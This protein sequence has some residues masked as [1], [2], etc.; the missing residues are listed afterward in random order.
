MNYD[1]SHCGNYSNHISQTFLSH[2]SHW[3]KSNNVIQVIRQLKLSTLSNNQINTLLFHYHTNDNVYKILTF[4]SVSVVF[5]LSEKQYIWIDEMHFV[6]KFHRYQGFD[7]ISSNINL[8]RVAHLFICV[9]F[10]V[11]LFMC[12]YLLSFQF[13]CPLRFPHKNDVRFVLTQ[14]FRSDMLLFLLSYTYVMYIS[15]CIP[16]I[17]MTLVNKDY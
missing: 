13:W 2:S 5:Y 7:Q 15:C 10:Y 9:F 16:I 4:F 17:D 8:P 14:K 11:V 12:L 6:L 1:Y 3:F